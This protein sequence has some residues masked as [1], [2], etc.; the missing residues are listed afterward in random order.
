MAAPMRPLPRRRIG[1]DRAPLFVFV[2]DCDVQ[3]TNNVSERNLRPG[4]IFRQ[5]TNGFGAEW[6]R[7]PTPQASM[8]SRIILSIGTETALPSTPQFPPR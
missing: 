8:G 3:A 1:R 5:V 4:V 7:R 2:V 6:L